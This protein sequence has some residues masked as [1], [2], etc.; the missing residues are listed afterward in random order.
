MPVVA[1][2]FK[3]LGA[4]LAT[5]WTLIRNYSRVWLHNRSNREEVD[6]YNM[7]DSPSYEEA[8]LYLPQIVKGDGAISGLRTFMR[9][10][11]RSTAVSDTHK[12]APLTRTEV[13]TFSDL[14]SVD[15]YHDSHDRLKSSHFVGT[16]A[17]E[18]HS[19]SYPIPQ[20]PIPAVLQSESLWQHNQPRHQ[21]WSSEESF[22]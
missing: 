6:E 16:V 19:C 3:A 17:H 22:A 12:T 2:P 7:T 14:N 20:P 15:F 18:N 8:K 21:K 13:F 9:R 11:Y 1:L 4:S 10:A 5:S